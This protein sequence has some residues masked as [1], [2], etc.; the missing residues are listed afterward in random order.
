MA[1]KFYT[2]VS[3]SLE[4]ITIY[5]SIRIRGTIDPCAPSSTVLDALQAT[6]R[7]CVL[8]SHTKDCGRTFASS[9]DAAICSSLPWN[10]GIHRSTPTAP[11]CGL[12][13]KRRARHVHDITYTLRKSNLQLAQS[14]AGNKE[15]SSMEGKIDWKRDRVSIPIAFLIFYSQKEN[16][17]DLINCH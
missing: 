8:G 12:R 7:R 3:Q 9:S 17:G 6:E 16:R 15:R 11:P 1:I 13:N 10:E 2:T 14:T 4:T 5:N